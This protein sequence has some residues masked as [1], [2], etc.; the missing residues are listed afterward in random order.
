[1]DHQDLENYE[2][3]LASKSIEL[4]DKEMDMYAEMAHNG[5]PVAKE[6]LNRAFYK[7]MM[8]QANTFVSSTVNAADLISCGVLGLNRAIERHNSKENGS[9]FRKYACSFIM[10]YISRGFYNGNNT[11]KVSSGGRLKA[12][13]SIDEGGVDSDFLTSRYA[14]FQNQAK[15]SVDG[16]GRYDV[17][18]D[19][20]EHGDYYCKELVDPSSETDTGAEEAIK[21]ALAKLPDDEYRYIVKA[22]FGILGEEYKTRKELIAEG[23]R[24]SRIQ[25]A[26]MLFVSKIRED[27]KYKHLKTTGSLR[28]F[29]GV[30]G[31][32]RPGQ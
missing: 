7:F 18:G 10:S 26:R 4:S 13:R 14:L 19:P 31:Y 9:G 20:N 22:S 1:M 30:R 11:I 8:Y 17:K 21:R 3:S 27:P 25:K 6:I 24:F 16:L 2:N 5:D 12:K 23:K 15:T 29:S 32:N 28:A